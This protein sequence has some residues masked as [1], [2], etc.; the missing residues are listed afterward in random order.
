MLLESLVA[1]LNERARKQV[2]TRFI[3]LLAHKDYPINEFADAAASRAA[4]DG[5]GEAVA[6]SHSDSKAVWFVFKGRLTE[7]GAVIRRAL[8]QVAAKQF[9]WIC[10]PLAPRSSNNPIPKRIQNVNLSEK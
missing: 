10:R 8:T 1:W 7:W 2:V 6:L 4:M 3:K 5:D 9:I